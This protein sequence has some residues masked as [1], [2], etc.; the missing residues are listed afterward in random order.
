MKFGRIPV[1]DAEGALLAHT[2]RLAKGVFKKGRQLSAADV[3]TL[4]TNGISTIVAARLDAADVHEDEAA[5]RVA[6][7]LSGEGIRVATPHAGRCNLY[8]DVRGIWVA[9]SS[10]IDAINCMDEAITVATLPSHRLVDASDMVATVKIIPFAV[11]EDPLAA[12]VS[13]AGVSRVRIAP[14]V[15]RRAG[16][17]MTQVEGFSDSVLDRAVGNQVARLHFLGCELGRESRCRHDADDVSRAI[18]SMLDDKLNPILILGASA[19]VDRD[20]VVPTALEE[21]GGVVEHLGMPVDPGNLLM[22]GRH[23]KT[24]VIGVPGCA[25]SLKPSGFDDVLQRVVAGLAVGSETLMR[26]GAGGLLSEITERPQPRR[27]ETV[28][29]P[30]VTGVVLA[31]GRSSR[32]GEANKLLQ[33]VEGQPMVVRAVAALR[34]SRVDAITVITGH[35]ADAVRKAI[36]TAFGDEDGAEIRFVHNSEFGDGMSTSLRA[37]VASANDATKAMVFALGDMPWVRHGHVDALIDAFS[38]VEGATICVPTFENK[39]GNPVLF[40][41]EHFAAI[42][43]LSGDVGARGVVQDNPHSVQLVALDE[44]AVLLDVDTPEMLAEVRRRGTT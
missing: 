32:M 25:R 38:P 4:R 2:M 39:R 5:R 17:I 23:G 22:L 20:D 34:K 11:P 1:A 41:R 37:A 29:R 8:A 7:A 6:E 9:P 40:G 42:A 13:E 18:Q 36:E 30:Q 33:E 21:A 12:A 26:M 16:L 27:G 15:P 3:E 31:A 44:G 28:E 24:T 43:K 14:L 19:I 10:I 35:E